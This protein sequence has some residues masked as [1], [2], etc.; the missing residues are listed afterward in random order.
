MHAGK[1]GS[2]NFDGWGLVLER[3]VNGAQRDGGSPLFGLP[4]KS[5]MVGHARGGG[6]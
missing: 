5:G 2:G 3:E 1:E 6:G 4:T